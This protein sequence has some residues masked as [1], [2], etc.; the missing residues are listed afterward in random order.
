MQGPLRLLPPQLVPGG[1]RRE[2]AAGP[3]LQAEMQVC[4]RVRLLRQRF[5]LRLRADAGASSPLPRE[6]FCSFQAEDGLCPFDDDCRY[7]TARRLEVSRDHVVFQSSA[8]LG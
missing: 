8:P 4:N 7:L 5:R 3:Q 2:G 1:R 6:D